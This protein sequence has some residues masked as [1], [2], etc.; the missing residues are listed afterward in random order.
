L[1]VQKRSETEKFHEEVIIGVLKILGL[2]SRIEKVLNFY[3]TF[4]SSF[5]EDGIGLWMLPLDCFIETPLNHL[6][7]GCRLRLNRVSMRKPE[8]LHATSLCWGVNGY[9]SDRR[10]Q[11]CVMMYPEEAFTK[12]QTVGSFRIIRTGHWIYYSRHYPCLRSCEGDYKEGLEHGPWINYDIDSSGM[13]R[14][15]CTVYYNGG[16]EVASTA[17]RCFIQSELYTHTNLSTELIVLC[18][19]YLKTSDQT[20]LIASMFETVP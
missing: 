5:E 1:Y 14:E 17:V 3:R 12:G 18:M 13:L 2:K 8:H 20:D 16:D 6:N 11:G 15:Y 4:P 9:I 19:S 7:E 10:V